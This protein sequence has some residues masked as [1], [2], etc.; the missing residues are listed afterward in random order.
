MSIF[1]R[2]GKRTTPARS[3][4]VRGFAAAE[5]DRMLANWRY[6]GGFTS[7]EISAHLGTIR[8]RS[9]QMFKDSPHYRKFINSCAVNI[10]GTGFSLKSKPF[11]GEI[12]EQRLDERAARI[13]EYHWRRFCTQRDPETKLTFCDAAGRMTMPQMDRHNAKKWARDGEYFM[14]PQVADNEYGITFKRVSADAC[15]H[16]Y[17]V[18]RLQNG[19]VVHCGVERDPGTLRAVAYYFSTTPRF[20]TISVM[21]RPLLRIP[22]SRV[23][24]GFT[25]EDSEQPRGVPWAHA[26][27][28]KLKMLDEY[29]KAELTA[30]RDEA[31]SVRTYFAPKGEE[32]QIA[33]LTTDENKEAANAL[34]ME[35]EPGQAEIL[36]MGWKQEIHTPQ[37]PN[38]ELTNFK[39]SMQRD[40]ASG[41]E[42]EYAGA[43]N[44][45]ARVS[46]SSVRQG[47][48]SER[49][50][51]M[52]KQDDMIAQNKSLAFLMW[53]ESFLALRVSG[54]LP[55][56]KFTKFAEHLFRGRRWGWIDP[57]KD[58]TAAVIATEKG[59]KTDTQVTEDLGGDFDD[60]I[61]GIKREDK[62]KEGT[63]LEKSEEANSGERHLAILGKVA[64]VERI[65][66]EQEQAQLTA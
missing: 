38:R 43:F 29:D 31:C 15:N 26:T 41:F 39:S 3:I 9:R 62:A 53:L 6:D 58:M 27:L 59:W 21:G 19:N 66:H 33:D 23:I 34:I 2:K 40:V 13:I 18:A 45:W 56:A 14:L 30:A 60:N 11:D 61:A 4:A 63:R 47:V 35:K 24:H 64:E 5:T 7:Q 28:V 49:D 10:V 20:A 25:E 22:A 17:N 51:W 55:Q 36:P 44:D 57:L 46:F 37:H 16:L 54:D 50:V 12:W 48:M 52:I 32:D 65:S 42:V 1:S 8:A